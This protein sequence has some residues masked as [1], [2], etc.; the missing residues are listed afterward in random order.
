MMEKGR[1]SFIPNN[2][3][4]GDGGN[5]PLYGESDDDD[6]DNEDDNDAYNF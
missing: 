6:D 2:V 1:T 4:L 5:A 3:E